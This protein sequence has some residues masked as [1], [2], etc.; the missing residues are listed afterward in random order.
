ML[1][2]FGIAGRLARVEMAD[3]E[4]ARPDL[5]REAYGARELLKR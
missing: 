4:T 3:L 5:S 1:E 2:A